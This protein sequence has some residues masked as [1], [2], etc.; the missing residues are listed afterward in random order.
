[1]DWT[2]V[3]EALTASGPLALALGGGC[4]ALWGALQAERAGRAADALAASKELAEVNEAYGLRLQ[5]IHQKRVD[6][7]K[8]LVQRNAQ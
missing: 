5:E 3:F 6:D 7:L 4:Y 1:M 2:K 8:A